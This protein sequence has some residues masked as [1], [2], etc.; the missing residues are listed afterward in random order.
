MLCESTPDHKKNSTKTTM[1]T[2]SY[3]EML[4]YPTYEDRVKYLQLHSSVSE[5]TFGSMRYLNQRFYTSKEWRDFRRSIIVRDCG[6]DLA[7]PELEIFHGLV[8]H[9]INPITEADIIDSSP[10]LFDPENVVCVSSNTHRLIHY[11][12]ESSVHEL[13]TVRSPN[14]TCPWK[15]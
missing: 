10:M 12:E 3:S 9:H 8:L 1:Y 6:C 2:R 15:L 7:I 5:P 11:S 4:Q 14:D 13:L